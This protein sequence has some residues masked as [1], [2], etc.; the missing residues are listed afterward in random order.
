M[1]S[2]FRLDCYLGIASCIIRLCKAVILNIIFMARLDWSFLGRPLEEYGK[3]RNLKPHR[4]ILPT[5]SDI[6]FAAYVSYLHIEV[7]QTNPVMLG[8]YRRHVS[9]IFTSCPCRSVLLFGLR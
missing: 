6:G 4:A 3:R 9:F 8:S 2:L 1:R 5:T 7:T